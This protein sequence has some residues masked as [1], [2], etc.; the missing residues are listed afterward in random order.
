MLSYYKGR[1]VLVTGCSSGIGGAVAQKLHAAGAKVIG[2][3]RK[4]PPDGISEFIQT[5]LNDPTSIHETVS[6]LSSPIWAVFNCAGLSGGAADPVT[7]LRVNFLGLRELN[8]GVVPL[9]P[10]GGAIVS[11]ASTAGQDYV[12]HAAEVIGLVRTK[13]Y[14][15]AEAWVK[16]NEDYVRQ[17][18]GY[19]VS[20]D[21]LVVYT[22][23]R[24]IDLAAHGVRINVVGPGVTDTPMLEDSFKAHGRDAILNS[25]KP[26]GRVATPEEQANILIYL[27]SDMASYI[28]GQA[29]WSDGGVVNRK[30]VVDVLEGGS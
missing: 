16:E 24:C 28:N 30:V 13:D 29:I 14:G 8:E 22:L 26:L 2:V 3:D 11:T 12:Q 10:S 15:Q 1:E 21:A 20:K 25:F 7:V 17:R 23:D 4:A 18:G 5:D 6:K 9:I 19:P 27:N